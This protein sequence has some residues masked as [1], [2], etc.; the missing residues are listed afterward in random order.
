VLR[1]EL[2]SSNKRLHKSE[3]TEWGGGKDARNTG[4]VC[5]PAPS[6]RAAMP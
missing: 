3:R 6:A 1:K 2:E 5:N 4:P